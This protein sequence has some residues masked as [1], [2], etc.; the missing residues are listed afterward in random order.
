MTVIE[1]SP[2][3]IVLYLAAGTRYKLRRVDPSAGFRLHIG[4]WTLSDDLWRVD[5][6][7]IMRDGDDHAYL[8]FSSEGG[9]FSSWYVNLKR[10]YHRTSI[11]IDFVD[12]F[13]AVA[14]DGNLTI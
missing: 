1:D 6:V 13:L 8:G 5:L 12:H 11:G 4:E 9:A 14:I 7:R 2:G 10:H 3:R